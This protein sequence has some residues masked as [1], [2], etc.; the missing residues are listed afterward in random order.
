VWTIDIYSK[1]G[2]LVTNIALMSIAF[3]FVGILAFFAA[4]IL[5]TLISV[6]REKIWL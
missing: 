3:G 1:E 2:R 4:V 6:M 5:F